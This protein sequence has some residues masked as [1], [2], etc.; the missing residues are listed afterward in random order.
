MNSIEHLSEMSNY[1]NI[2][3]MEIVTSSR[4][5]QQQENKLK[6][7]R[8]AKAKSDA[9]TQYEEPKQPLMMTQLSMEGVLSITIAEPLTHNRTKSVA[10]PLTELRPSKL[11]Y[12]HQEEG[13][14]STIETKKQN[15]SQYISKN[16]PTQVLSEFGSPS[17]IRREFQ[18]TTEYGD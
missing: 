12:L 18:A 8:A 7:L 6:A 1:R 14:K 15:Y 5:Y 3:V 9:F 2:A 16:L 4:V 10:D 17:P 11:K 13:D